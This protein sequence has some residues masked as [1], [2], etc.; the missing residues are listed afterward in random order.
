[1]LEEMQPMYPTNALLRVGLAERPS[2][3]DEA[4]QQLSDAITNAVQAVSPGNGSPTICIE[5]NETSNV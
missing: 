3:S 1:M 4:F 5:Q 2:D